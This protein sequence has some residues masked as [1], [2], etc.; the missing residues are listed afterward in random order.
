MKRLLLILLFTF[1]FASVALAAEVGGLVYHDVNDTAASAYWQW[2]DWHD[3]AL[4]GVRVELMGAESGQL[5]RTGADG[6]FS[7]LGVEP[8]SYLVDITFPAGEDPNC[9]SHNR[10]IRLPEAIREGHIKLVAFGDSNGVYGSN[11]PYPTWLAEYLTPLAE[12]ELFNLSVEGTTSWDW[13]PGGSLFENTLSPELADADV[14]TFTLGGN[15]Y[16]NYF[17]Y[18]PYTPEQIWQLLQGLPTVYETMRANLESIIAEVR[19]RAPQADLVYVIYPCFSN[20]EIWHQMLGEMWPWMRLGNFAMFSTI[21][22]QMGEQSFLL[23]ADVLGSF[24]PFEM[25]DA[26]LFDQIHPND[27]G[28]EWYARQVFYSLGGVLVDADSTGLERQIALADDGAAGPR[29]W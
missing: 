19:A 12:T 24:E 17:G 22:H 7:F 16:L 11:K 3:E 13:Q 8:G 27:L 2:F 5:T 6:R 18:P 23:L 25:I 29:A 14:I 15:D 4:P 20:S 26:Y 28:H 9:V 1:V 10:A 21:R